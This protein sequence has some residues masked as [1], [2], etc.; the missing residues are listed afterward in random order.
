MSV[1]LTINGVTFQYPQQFDKNWGPTL[2]NWSIAVTNALK[3][4]TGGFLTLPYPSTGINFANATSTGF[5]PLTV[6][7][8]NPLTFNGVAIGATA[9]LTNGHIYVGNI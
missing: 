8:S 7:S 2:T 6:N 4:L 3:P 1:P 9:S 5:L